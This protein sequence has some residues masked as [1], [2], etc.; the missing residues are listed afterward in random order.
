MDYDEQ[1]FREFLI[2]FGELMEKLEPSILVLEDNPQDREY[3]EE[4][5]RI[6]HS[7]KGMAS[8]FNLTPVKIVAHRLEDLLDAVREERVLTSGEAIKALYEG[9][10]VLQRLYDEIE[11]GNRDVKLTSEEN[12]FVT[13]VEDLRGEGLDVEKYF[14]DM[15]GKLQD[16]VSDLLADDQYGGDSRVQRLNE[17]IMQATATL[18][19]S[20]EAKTSSG[21]PIFSGE[22]M[23]EDLNLAPEIQTLEEISRRI[24]AEEA[25]EVGDEVSGRF[26]DAYEGLKQKV[27]RQKWP[28]LGAILDEVGNEYERF[29]ETTG[30]CHIFTS[31]VLQHL[32]NFKKVFLDIGGKLKQ[33]SEAAE[34]SSEKST[35]SVSDRRTFRVEESKVDQFMDYVGELIITGEMYEHLAE[36]LNAHR[37]DTEIV[38]RVRETNQ[39]F[40]ALSDKLQESL[41]NIRRLPVNTLLKKYPV[42]ARKLAGELNKQVELVLSGEEQEVDK[43]LLEILETPLTHLIRNA[44]DHGIESPDRRRELGKSESGKIEISVTANAEELVVE[45]EDDGSGLNLEKIKEAAINSGELTSAEAEKLTQNELVQFVFRSGFSTAEETTD[46]SGRGVGLDAV[47]DSIKS[48]GG[49]I[50]VETEPDQGTKWRLILPRA[51]TVVVEEGLTVHACDQRFIVPLDNVWESISLNKVNTTTVEGRGKMVKLRDNL[52]PIYWLRHIVDSTDCESQESSTDPVV[53][54]LKEE[55]VEYALVVDDISE[56]KKVVVQELGPVFK[57]VEYASGCAQIGDGTVSLILDVKGLQI[58]GQKSTQQ[59]VADRKNELIEK[60][61]I[62]IEKS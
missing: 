5:F 50:D 2:E 13:R 49:D 33:S 36:T 53:L 17:E 34:Q 51:Q 4:P 30:I 16:I 12:E 10:E 22:V 24:C 19:A 8:F 43:S 42:M 57:N 27:D 26:K 11:A 62:G 35:A 52:Y 31:S 37:V 20:T 58:E 54:I 18:E 44:V 40:R 28:D 14:E 7:I 55:D 45:I 46:V 32:K 48:V 1:A 47:A 38:S 29:K 41:L 9:T 6:L 3:V 15:V 23:L 39:S 21:G 25:M 59:P 56:Q 61:M 60:D